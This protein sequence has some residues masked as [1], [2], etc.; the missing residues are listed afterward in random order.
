MGDT[1]WAQGGAGMSEIKVIGELREALDKIGWGLRDMGCGHIR[2]INHHG[3]ATAFTI[4]PGGYL[5]ILGDDSAVSF[6][7]GKV[8]LD[9][10]CNDAVSISIGKK[11]F[12][13]FYNF[14]REYLLD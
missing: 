10:S 3:K 14:K 12:V 5:E 1:V 11:A 13:S 9:T 7:L 2:V 4:K 8:M 6:D